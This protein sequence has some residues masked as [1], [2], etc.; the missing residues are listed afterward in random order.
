M[1]QE[2]KYADGTGNSCVDDFPDRIDRLLHSISNVYMEDPQFSAMLDKKGYKGQG[3][4]GYDNPGYTG[5]KGPKVAE[6]SKV[7]TH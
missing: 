1:E 7:H 6:M 5:P 4:K 2:R 3:A